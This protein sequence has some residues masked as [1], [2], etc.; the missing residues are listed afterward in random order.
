MCAEAQRWGEDHSLLQKPGVEPEG[1][2]EDCILYCQRHS[3]PAEGCPPEHV[4]PLI[5]SHLLSRWKLEMAKKFEHLEW[6]KQYCKK[7]ELRLKLKEEAR[8]QEQV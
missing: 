3:I 7:R 6:S 4:R 8:R 5:A 2:V 1:G